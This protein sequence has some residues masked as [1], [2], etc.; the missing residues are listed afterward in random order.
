MTIKSTLAMAQRF[1]LLGTLTLFCSGCGYS[2]VGR[3]SNLPPEVKKIFIEPLENATPR[4]QVEQI[5]TQ[6]IIEE[7]VTR[8]R[9]ELISAKASADAVLKGKVVSF[10]VRPVAFDNDGLANNFEIAITADMKF[11]RAARAGETEATV[12]WQNARYSYRQDY[13]LEAGSTSYFDRENLAI[14]ETAESFA[15][16]LIT[17]LLEGF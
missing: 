11:E 14:E 9:F 1:V 3:A 15:E 17:D 12:L 5:L 8:R 16:T 2:L 4:S 6:A 13:P 7:M 10:T